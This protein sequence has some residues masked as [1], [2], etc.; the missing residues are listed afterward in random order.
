M[1]SPSEAA[2][3]WRL[4]IELEDSG[5]RRIVELDFRQRSALEPQLEQLKSREKRPY[6]R[7]LEFKNEAGETLAVVAAA[8]VR[9]T[10]TEL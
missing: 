6:G 2:C 3:G 8:Y 9:H 10:I 1:T 5:R 4:E 7:L